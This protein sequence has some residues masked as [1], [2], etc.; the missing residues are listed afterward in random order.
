MT[1]EISGVMKRSLSTV[2]ECIIN[3]IPNDF[4]NKPKVEKRLRDI[5]EDD[6]QRPDGTECIAWNDTNLVLR[7]ELMPYVKDE[8]KWSW[9]DEIFDFFSNGRWLSNHEFLTITV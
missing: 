4:E 1:M 6:K 8:V 2:I 5:V 3:K 9:C 7:Q